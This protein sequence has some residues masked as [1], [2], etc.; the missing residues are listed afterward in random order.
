M[1][2]VNPIPYW[3]FLDCLMVKNMLDL[4]WEKLMSGILTIVAGI[5]PLEIAY[6]TTL[7][8]NPNANIY[9]A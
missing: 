2:I 4:S 8:K 7:K 9:A 5:L 3:S 6:S 1:Q